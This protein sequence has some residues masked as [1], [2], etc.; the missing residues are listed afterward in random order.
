MRFFQNM[1]ESLSKFSSA[2][3]FIAENCHDSYE[4]LRSN[5]CQIS[6]QWL[7]ETNQASITRIRIARTIFLAQKNFPR[8]W[9]KID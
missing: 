9:K 8:S 1:Y 4:S 5:E 3:A 2:G 6:C 7:S